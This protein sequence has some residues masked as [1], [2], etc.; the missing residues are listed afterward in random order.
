MHLFDAEIFVF[1]PPYWR[2]Q[3]KHKSKTFTK[4][5]VR[6]QKEAI[7][8]FKKIAIF[9]VWWKMVKQ[10]RYDLQ[11]PQS[12]INFFFFLPLFSSIFRHIEIF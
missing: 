5:S 8:G 4:D 7:I 12:F 1:I 2:R 10:Q 11:T 9:Q 3:N 6:E